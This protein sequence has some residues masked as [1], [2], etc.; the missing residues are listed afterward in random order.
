MGGWPRSGSWRPS[1]PARL[2]LLDPRRMRP[3]RRNSDSP[4]AGPGQVAPAGPPAEGAAPPA[5]RAPT[6][7]KTRPRPTSSHGPHRLRAAIPDGDRPNGLDRDVDVAVARVI[8]PRKSERPLGS[9]AERAMRGRRA[10]KPRARHHAPLVVEQ[11]G[12]GC[13]RHARDDQRGDADTVG[14][15]SGPVQCDAFGAVEGVAKATTELG[16]AGLDMFEAELAKVFC[17]GAEA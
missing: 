3:Q 1:V 10:V 9:R 6:R 15:I 7:R 16:E 4:P 2:Q 14:R 11:P 13:A 8:A 5:W 17:G 12:D